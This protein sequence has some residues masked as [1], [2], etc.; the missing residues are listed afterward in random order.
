M[1]TPYF[2]FLC[3]YNSIM[4]K[5]IK[6]ICVLIL[7]MTII[8]KSGIAKAKS[9]L[10]IPVYST[11]SDLIEA[12]N[13]LRAA[14]GLAPYQANS[15]LMSI[16]QTQ[17][18]YLVS[19]GTFTHVDA[20]GRL[21]YQRALDAGYPVAGNI[22]TSVGFFAEN[23]SGGVGQTAEEAVQ[24]WM[25]DDAHKNTMLSGTLQDVGAGVGINGN[26]YYYVL[27]AGLSTGGTPVAYTPQ[28][29]LNP[30]TPTIIPNTPNADG[31][32]V[33]IAQ[34]G[35]TLGSLSLA[36]N[37]PLADIYKLNNL[38]LKSTIYVGQKIIIRAAYTPTPTLPTSTP[39][40]PAT[41]TPWPTSTSS[42]SVTP[43]PATPTPAPGI[44]ITKAGGAVG[45]IILSALIL[46]G[47]I[48]ILGRERK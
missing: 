10:R 26:T 4:Q 20:Q 15:I 44:P 47:L 35:D 30:S 45:V 32:I 25:G 39:T 46:A 19:I 29:P 8:P 6:A 9:S 18:E 33:H 7:I 17:A 40:I 1:T 38:T 41:I 24:S 28:I 13:A 12:V 14:N 34:A 37:V 43:L 23:I 5:T 16:A 3:H 27:D 2:Y 11:A 22:I 36:Y 42:P 21:P 31:S 48:T